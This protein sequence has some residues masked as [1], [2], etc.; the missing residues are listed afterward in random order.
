M[1]PQTAAGLDAIRATL[2]RMERRQRRQSRMLAALGAMEAAEMDIGTALLAKVTAQGTTVDSIVT[3]IQGLEAAGTI[4]A[5]TAA[6]INAVID[7]NET[8]LETALQPAP[9]APGA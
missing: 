9:P 7:G 1:D 3:L 4:S 5:D 6:Q 8:K 2:H